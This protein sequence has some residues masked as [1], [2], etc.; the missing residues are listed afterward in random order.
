MGRTLLKIACDTLAASNSASIDLLDR[1]EACC[2]TCSAIQ[3]PD[4]TIVCNVTVDSIITSSTG[5]GMPNPVT[6]FITMCQ[7]GTSPTGQSLR[8]QHRQV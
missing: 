4:A 8:H 1:R 7:A 5:L 3:M 2:S 6:G